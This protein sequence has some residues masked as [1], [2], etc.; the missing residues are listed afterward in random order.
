MH[1]TVLPWIKAH[2]KKRDEFIILK[3]TGITES[4][5]YERIKESIEK[6]NAIRIAYLP[7]VFGVDLR[8]SS[9]ERSLLDEFMKVIL[10]KIEKYHYGS[11]NESLEEIVGHLLWKNKK[12]LAIAESCSGGLISDRL[13]N[14]PGSS[15]YLKGSI[16]AYIKSIKEDILSIK[17]ETL[18]RYDSVSKE[19]AIEMAKKIRM[20]FSSDIALSST[21]IAGPDGSNEDQPLGLVY[22]ALATKESVYA[23]KFIF[24]QN[25][26]R[27]KD[28]TS[29]AALNILRCHLLSKN[30]HA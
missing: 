18:D 3:T 15:S 27:N 4:N 17:K 16:V 1:H 7:S 22:I 29:Q 8:I 26:K 20:K 2:S 19:V 9:K 11:N 21:G 12:T 23:K 5:L 28:M 24:T 6:F 25:R 13:T 14:I 10:P 30:P